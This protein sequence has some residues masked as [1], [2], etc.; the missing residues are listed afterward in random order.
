MPS[1]GDLDRL[2]HE[3][4]DLFNEVWRSP[5][6]SAKQCF[7]PAVDCF[8]TSDPA[9]LVIVVELAGIDPDQIH[10]F[11]ADKS[12]VISGERRRPRPGKGGQVYQRM[13]M[14]YGAFERHIPLPD[15]VEAEAGTATY[16]RGLLTVVVPIASRPAPRG[17]V[18][19]PIHREP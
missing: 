12:I 11:A 18:A 14:D 8:R 15:D 13:E 2:R 10:V 16:E 5:R 1:G 9:E 4:E 17:R 19:I 7:R 3:L 6:F